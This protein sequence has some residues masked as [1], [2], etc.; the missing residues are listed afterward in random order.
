M[1]DSLLQQILALAQRNAPQLPMSAPDVPWEPYQRGNIDLYN[2]PHVPNPDGRISTVRSMS[3]S[4]DSGQEILVPTVSPDGRLL[5]DEEAIQQYYKTRQH[6]GMF[7]NP[8]TATRFASR[9]HNEYARGKYDS[10]K[11]K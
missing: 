8:A 7:P 11:K 4:D 9:L 5:S 6:L 2:R 1:A 10:P 3:F